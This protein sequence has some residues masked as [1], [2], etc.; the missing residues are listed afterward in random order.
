MDPT[1]EIEPLEG[2]SVVQ[3]FPRCS[4]QSRRVCYYSGKSKH[5]PLQAK[6]FS[7][8]NNVHKQLRLKLHKRPP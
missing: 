2:M 8:G 4:S 1:L 6:I 5:M 7:R 3:K